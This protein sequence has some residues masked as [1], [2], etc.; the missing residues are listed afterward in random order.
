MIWRIR[1]EKSAAKD[2]AALSN[3]DRECVARFLHERL[4]PRDD[5]RELGDALSGPLAGLW[6]YRVG[7]YRII[8]R[9]DDGMV[10]ILVIRIGHRGAV[11][12]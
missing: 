4:S 11:Y 6:K 5:P 10:A 9:I 2:I 3:R 8:A 1:F 7:D 12:R